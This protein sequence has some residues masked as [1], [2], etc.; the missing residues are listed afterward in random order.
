MIFEASSSK[1][2]QTIK[3][4]IGRSSP[5]YLN[6]SI[7]LRKSLLGGVMGLTIALPLSDAAADTIKLSAVLS[8]TDQIRLN[9]SSDENHFL[10]LTQREGVADESGIFAGASVTEY[11][12]HDI[13]V[14]DGGRAQGYLEATTTS[15]DTAYFAWR[16]Q[17][18]FVV[19]SDGDTKVI[20]N[21]HWELVDGT[22][23]FASMRGV[24]T[25]LLEFV[26]KTDRRY[27][28]EG[29]ISSAP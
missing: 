21:G 20:N 25:L 24:G 5:M 15:G 14:G 1:A 9:F 7:N 10:A 19:D 27:V 18:K 17:A 29:D 12:M 28:L 2:G 6:Q 3:N 23:D 16:L 11:G 13:I 4:W 22:G 26:D 8:P